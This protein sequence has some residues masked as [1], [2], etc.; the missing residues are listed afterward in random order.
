MP[1][2]C[3]GSLGLITNFSSFEYR[4]YWV[5]LAFNQ[6]EITSI[7]SEHKLISKNVGGFN[8]ITVSQLFTNGP[9]LQ[10]TF[11]NLAIESTVSW[12]VEAATLIRGVRRTDNVNEAVRHSCK[13]HQRP[14]VNYICP[15]AF[16]LQI[17]REA[18]SD[19]ELQGFFGNHIVLRRDLPNFNWLKLRLEFGTHFFFRAKLGNYVLETDVTYDYACQTLDVTVPDYSSD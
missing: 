19:T 4:V 12:E 6:D 14:I 10:V 8:Q 5:R 15:R 17:I 7:A 18:V 9:T 2:P 3:Q 13:C 16:A 11:K 1:C